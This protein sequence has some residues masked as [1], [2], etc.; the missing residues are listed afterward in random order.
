MKK[1]IQ[2]DQQKQVE[3]AADSLARILIQQAMSKRNSTASK[4]IETKYG[5]SNE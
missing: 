4:Q 2:I 3:L 5:K 1:Q